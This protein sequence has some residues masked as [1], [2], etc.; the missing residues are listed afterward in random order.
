MSKQEFTHVQHDDTSLP[1]STTFSY[2]PFN[3]NWN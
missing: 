3:R 2:I 1:L